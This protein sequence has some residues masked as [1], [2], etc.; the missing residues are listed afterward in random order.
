MLP[1]TITEGNMEKTPATKP[2]DNDGSNTGNQAGLVIFFPGQLFAG[3]FSHP[4]N[5]GVPG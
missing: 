3:L 1:L 4:G 5:T 2:Y